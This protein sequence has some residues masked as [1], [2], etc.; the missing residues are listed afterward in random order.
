MMTLHL[1]LLPPAPTPHLI[2]RCHHALSRT[3]C[4]QF[5]LLPFSSGVEESAHTVRLSFLPSLFEPFLLTVHYIVT[6]SLQLFHFKKV[7]A[8]LAH[9][10]SWWLLPYFLP[11]F[12]PHCPLVSYS[13]KPNPLGPPGLSWLIPC[14][15][16][17]S[18]P[19]CSILSHRGSPIPLIKPGQS[20]LL[21]L[22]FPPIPQSNPLLSSLH[23]VFS[24][25]CPEFLWQHMA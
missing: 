22:H 15:P 13:G 16:L 1:N 5:C 11:M 7:P 18:L 8:L 2:V 25:W 4:V 21:V 14:F 20:C 23:D 17:M 12:F 3:P 6:T 9:S 10:L 24:Q 19:D